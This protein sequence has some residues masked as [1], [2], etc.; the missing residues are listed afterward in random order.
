MSW[1]HTGRPGVTCSSRNGDSPLPYNT[2]SLDQA[3]NG[4]SLP[5]APG[6]SYKTPYSMA[7]WWC[8]NG[9]AA[10]VGVS[11]A[12]TGQGPKWDTQFWR[13]VNG[14]TLKALMNC[15]GNQ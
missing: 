13:V 1:R 14:R 12:A 7:V 8:G 3:A 15:A 11:V 6:D 4:K 5:G 10:I 9:G 2:F